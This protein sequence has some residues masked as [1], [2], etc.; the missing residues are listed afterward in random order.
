MTKKVLWIV[1]LLCTSTYAQRVIHLEEA[2]SIA[3]GESYSK[4]T[5]ANSL[6]YSQKS[7]EAQKLALMSNVSLNLNLP[8]YYR[9][10][11]QN[12]NP[13]TQ[14]NEYFNTE[15]TTIGGALSLNQPVI[16]TGGTISLSGSMKGNRQITT[17]GGSSDTYYSDLS[18]SIYQPIFQINTMQRTLEKAEINLKKAER[19]YTQTE[20]DIVY[21]VTSS[22]FNLIKL[23]KSIEIGQEKVKLTEDAYKTAASKFKVG[24]TSEDQALQL[25]LSLASARND[26]VNAQQSFEDAKNEFKL[27]IGIPLSELV[28]VEGEISFAPVQINEEEAIQAALKNRS[29]ILN[30]EMDIYMNQLDTEEINAR[31]NIQANISASYGVNKNAPAFNDVFNRLDDSR[32][33]SLNM[34]VPVF[35]WGKNRRDVEASKALGMQTKATLQYMKE[36]IKKDVLSAINKIK[37]ARTRVEVLGKTVEMSEKNYKICLD[38]FKTG[39]LSS[40]EL[41]QSQIK[42]TEAKMNMLSALID[43]RLSITDLERKTLTKYQ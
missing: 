30:A 33:I 19:S 13:I 37:S 14:T 2:L 7:L 34:K 22:F 28:D 21:N 29:E 41:S 18:I 38:K 15:S 10:L 27:L 12:F 1:L 43:Y 4:Q 17:L 6:H 5:A 40:N 31:T 20:K 26:L 23:K 16:Y 35:D 39:S 3:L 9:Q 32:Y 36:A 25:D 8:T 42:V 24:L 11:S